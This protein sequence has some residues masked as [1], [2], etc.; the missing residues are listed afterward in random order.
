MFHIAKVLKVIK[1]DGKNV[2]SSDKVICAAVRTWD[3]NTLILAVDDNIAD[4][5]KIDDFVLADYRI[6][7]SSPSP[8]HL[9][10]KILKDNLGKE[11]WALAISHFEEIKKRSGM[12]MQAVVAKQLPPQQYR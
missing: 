8:R 6:K 5:I 7:D 3:E 11:L 10:T 2:V 9:I 1:P 4:K 12:P